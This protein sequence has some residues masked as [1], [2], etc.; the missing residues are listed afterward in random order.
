MAPP[1]PGD[2]A[3]KADRL[4]GILR[5]MGRVA[6]AFS[7]GV[8][9]TLLLA[10]ARE[11]LGE[12]V[13]AVTAKSPAFP[14]RSLAEARSLAAS[15]GARHLVLETREV[16]LPDYRRNPP[17]RCYFCKQALLDEVLPLAAQEGGPAVVYGEVLDDASDFRPGRRAAVERGIRWPLAEAGFAKADVRALSRAM[18]LPTWDKPASPC[19]A[20]RFPYGTPITREDLAKVE[21]AEEA[22]RALG[23]REFRVRHHGPVARIEI[24]PADFEKVLAPSARES[25]VR[26]V[27][28]AGYLYVA[29]DLQG[30]RS[31]S[32]NEGLKR[33]AAPSG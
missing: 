16:D 15:L 7:G 30:F 32:L 26:D 4:R 12:N 5:S 1:L 27:K 33:P 3:A 29:L 23:I 21:A 17:D 8:D 18:N 25:L 28:R 11:V 6:V 24:L 19:L 20:S 9:S 14:A 31:G 13:L 2:L 10:I 22:V